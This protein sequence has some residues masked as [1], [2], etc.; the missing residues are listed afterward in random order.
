M[1]QIVLNFFIMK[2]ILSAFQETFTS[3][4]LNLSSKIKRYQTLLNCSKETLARI[5]KLPFELKSPNTDNSR[6]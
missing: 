4:E 2:S 3:A 6:I 5:L 1:F